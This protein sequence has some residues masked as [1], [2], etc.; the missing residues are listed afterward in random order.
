MKYDLL[1]ERLLNGLAKN[2]TLKQLAKKHKIS[3]SILKNQLK[4]GVKVEKEHT[5]KIKVA[6]KIAMDHL[7]EDPR[8]Y[9]KLKKIEKGK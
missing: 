8:Y 2:K 1:V 7:F 5:K 9:T 6:K 4:K 3:L